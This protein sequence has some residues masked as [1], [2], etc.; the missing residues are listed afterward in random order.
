MTNP[1][2]PAAIEGAIGIEPCPAAAHTLRTRSR[3]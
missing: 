2:Q 3:D 1:E